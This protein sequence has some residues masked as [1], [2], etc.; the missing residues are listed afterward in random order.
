MAASRVIDEAALLDL[1]VEVLFRRDADCRLTFVNEPDGDRAPILFLARGRASFRVAFRVG[2]PAEV[3]RRW[4]DVAARLPLWDGEA[5]DRSLHDELRSVVARDVATTA[6]EG[7]PAFRFGARLERAGV[8]VTQIDESSA[9]LLDRFFPY[10]RSVLADRH[11]V[12]G[13]VVDGAVVSACYSARRGPRACE[14]GVATEDAYRG[15]GYA[16]AVVAAWRQA[17]EHSD[18]VPLYSTSWDNA[19][20]LALARSLG[21]VAYADTL[22]IS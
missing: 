6:V 8:A 7:G 13:V 5:P 12:V 14:A 19:G 4:F 21:L 3:V 15:R 11:P 2:V 16:A 9:H 18:R 22:S 17:V 10:T 20:S 1:H